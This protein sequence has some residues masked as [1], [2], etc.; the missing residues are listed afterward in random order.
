MKT[1]E[2]LQVEN[3]ALVAERDALAALLD[4]I[5][6]ITPEMI[7]AAQVKSELGAYACGK[8]SGA[9]SLIAEI[10]TVMIGEF[11]KQTAP[12]RRTEK[13]RNGE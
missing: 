10:Y 5:K 1:Y 3:A 12:E 13:A 4:K 7:R 9:Y 8:L 2:E 11:M 6:F